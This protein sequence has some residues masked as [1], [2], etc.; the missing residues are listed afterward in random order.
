MDTFGFQPNSCFSFKLEYSLPFQ[1]IAHF[2]LL[3][4]GG[5]CP[6]DHL[7]YHSQKKQAA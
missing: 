1:Y 7:E 3:N 4:A 6:F 5:S 2:L